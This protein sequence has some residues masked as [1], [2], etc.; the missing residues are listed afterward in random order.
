[1]S[2]VCLF[3]SCADP[4]DETYPTFNVF[5]PPDTTEAGLYAAFQPAGAI[6]SV[7]VVRDKFTGMAKGFGFVNHLSRHPQQHAL[8][9]RV[10]QQAV[11]QCTLDGK[12]LSVEYAK[13]PGGPQP[14][15]PGALGPGRQ[16]Q[17][18]HARHTHNRGRASFYPALLFSSRSLFVPCLFPPFPLVRL[19]SQLSN[20]PRRADDHH[21]FAADTFARFRFSFS[22][23]RLHAS[24]CLLDCSS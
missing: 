6:H 21:P 14:G 16:S 11:H 10:A 18:T 12:V 3:S 20:N 24:T 8:E 5:V 22:L 2:F 23:L 7:N 17:S 19:T 9:L 15:P 13:I 4:F 1:L